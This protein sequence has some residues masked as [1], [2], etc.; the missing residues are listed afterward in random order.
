MPSYGENI[1]FINK[2]EESTIRWDSICWAGHVFKISLKSLTCNLEK[3]LNLPFKRH[4]LYSNELFC[5]VFF[6]SQQLFV[7]IGRSNNE[8]WINE[9]D[10][11]TWGSYQV[12]KPA[13]LII[14]MLFGFASDSV[15][16]K[17][18]QYTNNEKTTWGSFQGACQSEKLFRFIY[19]IT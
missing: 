18:N 2:I 4:V 7:G 1:L 8:I 5:F 19:L 16:D 13:R 10:N 17:V 15:S 6:S 12:D 9:R 3:Y 14:R 11:T